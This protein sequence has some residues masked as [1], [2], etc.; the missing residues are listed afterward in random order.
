VSRRGRQFDPPDRDARLQK[1]ELFGFNL[2]GFRSKIAAFTEM[3][4]SKISLAMRREV[5]DILVN[6]QAILVDR[7]LELA[8]CDAVSGLCP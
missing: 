4:R 7:A 2:S 8:P 6:P 3:H 5:V 1:A